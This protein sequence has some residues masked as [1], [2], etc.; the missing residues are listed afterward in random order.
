M[1]YLLTIPA[2]I[3]LV[4]IS[5]VLG[6]FWTGRDLG[7]SDAT[8]GVLL[9]IYTLAIGGIIAIG[10]PQSAIQGVPDFAAVVPWVMAGAIVIGAGAGIAQRR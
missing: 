3:A 7:R 1:S 4:G 6:G 2:A 5:G 10:G 9:V 8:A